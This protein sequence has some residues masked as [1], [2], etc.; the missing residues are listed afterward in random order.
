MTVINIETI[1]MTQLKSFTL[2]NVTKHHYFVLYEQISKVSFKH[3]SNYFV[4][5]S[6]IRYCM[7]ARLHKG[8]GR[9][10]FLMLI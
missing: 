2:F 5:L 6:T 10:E 1:L 7:H 4:T 3:Q 8:L 9:A